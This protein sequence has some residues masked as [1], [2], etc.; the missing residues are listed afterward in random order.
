MVGARTFLVSSCSF[1]P[2]SRLASSRNTPDVSVSAASSGRAKTPSMS[3]VSSN[4]G[5]LANPSGRDL[6]MGADAPPVDLGATPGP[7]WLSSM[8]RQAPAALGIPA[9]R[10]YLFGSS[11]LSLGAWMQLVALGYLTLRVTGSPA[12]VGLV[13]AADGI[14]AIALSLPAGALADRLSR[15]RILIGTTTTMSLTALLLALAASLHRVELPVLVGAAICFGAADA[16]DQPT[17]QA[18]VADLVPAPGLVGAAALTSSVGSVTRIVGP[19]VA[20][21][22]LGFWGAAS[23]FLAMGISG[24]PFLWILARGGWADARHQ[25]AGGKFRPLAQMLEGLRFAA[26]H[27]TVRA[28]LI[29]SLVLGLLGVGYM[30]F[31]P[32]FAREQ[33]HGGGQ[34]LGL[35]Y[36]LGGIGAL[37]GG[38]LI[39]VTSR[40]LHPGLM[41]AAAAPVYAGSLFGLTRASQMLLAVPCLI[42]ISLGFVAANTAMLAT[43]QTLT[44][45]HMRGRVLSLYTLAFSGAGPL[46][47]LLYAGL[48]RAIPLFQAIGVGAL[49]VGA[50]LLWS[51]TRL[52][53]RSGR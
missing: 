12:A 44:P 46:G 11:P 9:Y 3:V 8:R 35:M 20:G 42:G 15:R 40:R 49:V 25:T 32:V 39:S 28:I 50:A 29:A 51:S 7:G 4:L 10:R 41:L 18:L 16:F 19:A 13:G 45:G 31:L 6:E 17:R 24:L 1:E 21:V 14:P 48:S 53:I 2:P 37:A 27:P 38:V 22:L 47:T 23:C 5:P 30:P 26:R 52:G 33:L 43:L 36:S 34:V